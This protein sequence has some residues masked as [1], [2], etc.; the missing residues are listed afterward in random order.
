MEPVI[1]IREVTKRFDGK[2]SVTVLHKIDLR[3][4]R[5]EL[6]SMVGPSG[7]GQSTLLNLIGG[8]DHAT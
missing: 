4:H 6:V 3:I 2:R 8:L 7:S 5:G 1:E